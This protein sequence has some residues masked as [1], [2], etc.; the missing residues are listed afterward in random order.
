MKAGDTGKDDMLE[1]PFSLLVFTSNP[2]I[3]FYLSRLSRLWE[4]Q[5]GLL[6]QFSP[7]WSFTLPVFLSFLVVPHLVSSTAAAS[8]WREGG[9]WDTIFSCILLHFSSILT[10]HCHSLKEKKARHPRTKA[11]CLHVFISSVRLLSPKQKA[12]RELEVIC[13]LRT[14]WWWYMINKR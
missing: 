9:R 6:L 8:I 11:E 12:Q 7:C 3:A 1:G 14:S 4:Y 13:P 2:Y 10:Q 5:V